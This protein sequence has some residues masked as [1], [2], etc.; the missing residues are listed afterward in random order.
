MNLYQE[1]ILLN[2]FFKGKFVI[3][4]VI[5]YYKPLIE[6]QIAGRH[7][8]WANFIIPKDKIFDDRIHNDIVGNEKVYGFDISEKR[9]ILRNLV[10]PK[11]GLYVF[12]LAFK[13]KQITLCNL[14][15]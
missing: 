1:V 11:L 9:K 7:C 15:S 3:E 12:Y 8:F 14:N 5:P 10:N 13:E 6:P 4:N 2:Y